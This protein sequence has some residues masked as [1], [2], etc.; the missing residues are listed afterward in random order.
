MSWSMSDVA[1]Q[2]GKL[3]LVT[4]SNAGIGFATSYLL[5]GKGGKI[6][7][8]CRSLEK[9]QDALNRL[10]TMV[11]GADVSLM[12]LD[13]AS[14]A[15]VRSFAEAFLAKYDRL[16]VLINNAGLMMPP[17]GRT[18][19]GF[20]LQFGTN[21]LG[22]FLLTGLLLPVLINTPPARIVSLASLAHWN[23]R[24]DLNNLNAENSYG[25]I[26]AY[27]QS[28]L[29]NLM[30]AY[31]L[32]RRLARAGYDIVSVAAHPGATKSDLGRHSLSVR[33]GQL[34]AQSVEAGAMPS[35]RAAV[36][37]AVK[38]GEY[39]GPGGFLTI[40]GPAVQQPS[41][42]RSH[43]ETVAKELWNRCETLTSIAYLN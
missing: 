14:L 1:S 20:E 18:A 33:F 32:Q 5:A 15:S 42:K 27:C 24:I 7:M 30:I 26:N 38:G 9:G 17:L 22:H 19:D 8:A 3:F 29:A 37:P 12:Q 23:G 28:K 13:L 21:V 10:K 41:S 40:T 34:F 16:D 4:G 2:N 35:I 25:K 43:D 39:F 11:P 36:D 6:V 31:E